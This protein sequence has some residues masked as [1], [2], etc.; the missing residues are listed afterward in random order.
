MFPVWM[1]IGRIESVPAPHFWFRVLGHDDME[2]GFVA[3]IEM[4]E[5]MKRRAWAALAQVES[6]PDYTVTTF[7]GFPALQGQRNNYTA[8]HVPE[9]GIYVLVSDPRLLA[10]VRVRARSS[11]PE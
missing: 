7:N 3:V 6:F 5:V 9:L 10:D 2:D 11:K 8:I 4:D 1:S